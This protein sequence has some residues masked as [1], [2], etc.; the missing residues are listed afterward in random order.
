M[1]KRFLKV[2]AVSSLGLGLS[3]HNDQKVDAIKYG[4]SRI[5][6]SNRF[7]TAVNISQES[8]ETADKVIITNAR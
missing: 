7:E 6:G 2:M 4:V 5:E 1:D 3:L 8:Y